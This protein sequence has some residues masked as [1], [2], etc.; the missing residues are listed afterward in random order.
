MQ[1]HTRLPMWWCLY[2]SKNQWTMLH[3]LTPSA[4]LFCAFLFQVSM[5]KTNHAA[6]AFLL[7]AYFNALRDFHFHLHCYER[8]GAYHFYGSLVYFPVWY[9]PHIFMVMICRFVGEG[10]T[11]LCLKVY[12]LSQ[13][14]EISTLIFG[15][16]RFHLLFLFLSGIP[17][18]YLLAYSITPTDTEVT[19]GFFTAP[20][21]QI[22]W[23]NHFKWPVSEQMD[24][25]LSD[26]QCCLTSF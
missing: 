19:F 9:L 14:W 18:M 7:L 24:C 25:F 6:P 21:S 26:Q 20:F 16:N 23:Q 5:C 12:F 10:E 2:P 8:M 1:Y 4:R 3:P 11:S 13:S 22:N 15:K 17:M